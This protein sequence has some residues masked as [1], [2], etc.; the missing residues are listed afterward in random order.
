MADIEIS[1]HPRFDQ[2]SICIENIAQ[3]YRLVCT[4]E[5]PSNV[6]SWDC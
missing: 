2:P 1:I 6:K 4:S 3:H 5:K